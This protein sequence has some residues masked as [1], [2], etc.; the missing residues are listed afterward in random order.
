M[1]DEQEKY[2]E[3]LKNLYSFEQEKSNKQE[4]VDLLEIEIKSLRTEI[5]ESQRTSNDILTELKKIESFELKEK[6]NY[7]NQEIQN[8]HALLKN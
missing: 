1:L 2:E 6:I 8:Y 3:N 5:E 4:K 7:F